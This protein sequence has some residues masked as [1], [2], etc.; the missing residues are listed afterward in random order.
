MALSPPEAP[1]LTHWAWDS[2]C[3]FWEH[4]IQMAAFCP[5]HPKFMSF[6]PVFYPA[7]P[8]V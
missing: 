4:D 8:K 2:A 5:Q 1:I 7:A 6:S 3:E